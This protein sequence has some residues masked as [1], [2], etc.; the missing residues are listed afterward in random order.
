MKFIKPIPTTLN[1]LLLLTTVFFTQF[2]FSETVRLSSP[3]PPSHIFAKVSDHFSDLLKEK[4]EGR[5]KV[6]TYHF[7]KLGKDAENIRLMQ[8]GAVQFAVVPA[9][10]LANRD[11]SF[12]GWFLPYLFESVSEAGAAATLPAAREMLTT[13][14]GQGLVG[15]GYIMT[16][17]RQVLSVDKITSYKELENKKIRAFPGQVFNDW[18]LAN[19]AAA[20]ALPLPDIAPSLTTRLLDAVDVDLD[21]VV[22]LKLYQQ[23]PNILLTQ[24]MAFP[25]VMLV[26][27]KWWNKQSAEDKQMIQSAFSESEAWGVAQQQEADKE[28]LVLLESAGVSIST[29]KGDDGKGQANTV[30]KKY[31]KLNPLTESFYQ[32][33]LQAK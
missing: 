14:E 21:L 12:N 4:S 10:Y 17:M 5:Y 9:G 32:Q 31:T 25:G 8:T 26:S 20:T 30:V 3:V 6:K 7:G 29:L 2:S 16:G 22:A 24:H 15:L 1:Y 33:A 27:S 18:W 19:G 11:A 23:A 28:N 13:L